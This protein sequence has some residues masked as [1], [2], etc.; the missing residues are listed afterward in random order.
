[1]DESKDV[2]LGDWHRGRLSVLFPRQFHCF[3]TEGEV[4]VTLRF[5]GS[6]IICFPTDQLLSDLLNVPNDFI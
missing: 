5:E 1:M 2:T 6:K 3:P 4:E